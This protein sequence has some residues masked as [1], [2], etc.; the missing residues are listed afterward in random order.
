[1]Q[2]HVHLIP[3]DYAFIFQPTCCLF[4]D[5]QHSTATP[6]A[7]YEECSLETLLISFPSP[8]SHTHNCQSH[9]L[10]RHSYFCSLLHIFLCT[11]VMIG[12]HCASWCHSA[13]HATFHANICMHSSQYD[14]PHSLW[15]KPSKK[16]A[17]ATM[18]IAALVHFLLCPTIV[19]CTLVSLPLL[20]I[21]HS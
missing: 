13:Q 5:F 20:A 19:L 3:W 4:M 11:I 7:G 9:I 17:N 18:L 8:F 21:P 12:G 1:M 14:G 15:W 16:T 10:L 2:F 6:P